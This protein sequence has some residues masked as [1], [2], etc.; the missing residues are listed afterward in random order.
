MSPNR[1]KRH[2]VIL[3]GIQA[4]GKST[5]YLENFFKTH[6]R[7]NLDMLRTRHRE[8]VLV[9]ACIGAGI[10]FAVDNTNPSA[11]DRARYISPAREAGFTVAG[12]YFR[13]RL[14]E[15][16]ARNREREKSGRI[17]EPGIRSAMGRLALPG[18]DEGFDELYYVF[19]DD[20]GRFV[21]EEWRGEK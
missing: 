21:V 18:W 13:S 14:D 16:L 8:A 6:V 5:F 17:P 9:E 1:V 20:S 15:A 12:Y 11:G 4:T 3:M 10:N 7:I 19:I 2:A